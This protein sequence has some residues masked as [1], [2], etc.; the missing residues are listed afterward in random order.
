[1]HLAILAGGKGTRLSEVN[2]T[3][4]KCLTPVCGKPILHH[5]LEWAGAEGF[6]KVT[7]FLGY[8]SEQVT[9]WLSDYSFQMTIDTR[10]E[11]EPLGTAGAFRDFDWDGP[12]VVLYGDLVCN[13]D[14]QRFLNFHE[15]HNGVATLFVHPNDHP[16]DSDLICLDADNRISAMHLKPHTG[17]PELGNCVSAACYVVDSKIKDYILQGHQ[18]IDWMRDVFGTAFDNDAPLYGYRSSEYVKDMGTLDRLDK[19]EAH[20]EKGLVAAKTY[21]QKR[22]AIFFDR[23]GTL[24]QSN[25]HV[26]SI[27]KMKLEASAT[28]ALRLVMASTFQSIL[29]TN[30]PVVARGE[31][32]EDELLSIHA[33]FEGLLGQDGA[34]LDD[35]YYCPH[36]T[37][38]GFEGENKALKMKCECRKPGIK[39]MEEACLKHN[40]DISRSWFI[41]D[42]WRDVG[43]ANNMG[44]PCVYIG[45]TV[46]ELEDNNVQAHHCVSNVLE[47]VQYI[48]KETDQ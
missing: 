40:I 39:M 37:D 7:L 13:F 36:H 8:E 44:V 22:P 42:S 12:L 2:Q 24:N 38:S 18:K 4:P 9:D 5:Q 11:S 46:K 27:D 34:F 29:I 17:S 3:R 30:Q 1:M 35:L 41:G 25:G 47:A 48:L 45:D 10:V 19:V 26:N 32:T 21:R 6:E 31:C 16:Y 28:E 14:T 23:D 33:Y 43:A 15:V 20:I